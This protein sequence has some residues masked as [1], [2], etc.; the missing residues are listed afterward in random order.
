M[1]NLTASIV[2]VALLGLAVAEYKQFGD[3]A[4]VVTTCVDASANMMTL[5][6]GTCSKF[7]AK[8]YIDNVDAKLYRLDYTCTTCS[9]GKTPATSTVSTMYTLDSTKGG[10]T[11]AVTTDL[12]SKCF[13]AIVA[14]ST[15]AFSSLV[16]CNLF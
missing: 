3:S 5:K 13:A 4:G 10:S 7:N 9:S 8:I 14:F 15:L 12:S 11:T 6:C 16:A 2:L 1:R